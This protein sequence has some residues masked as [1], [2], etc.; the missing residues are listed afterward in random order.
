MIVKE[1][2]KVNQLGELESA[3]QTIVKKVTLDQ[4]MQVYLEDCA[5]ICKLTGAQIK[6]LIEC[7]KYSVYYDNNNK[8]L[9]N[10][11]CCN[12]Q[13]TDNCVKD[14]KLSPGTIRNCIAALVNSGMLIKDEVYR[15]VYYLN[16]KYFFKGKL[17][18]RLKCIKRLV[19]YQL[20]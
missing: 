10:S 4:F 6:V 15:G 3:E 18:D 14:T 5:G 9:G 16:A 12:R 1:T 8:K 11:I 7:W 13:F 19:E 2:V 17:S 20:E